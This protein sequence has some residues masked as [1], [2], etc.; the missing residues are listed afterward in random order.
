MSSYLVTSTYC[1]ANFIKHYISHLI[2]LRS[3]TMCSANRSPFA[4]QD[5]PLEIRQAIIQKVLD[6]II[7]QARQITTHPKLSTPAAREYR[8]FEGVQKLLGVSHQFG[9]ECEQPIELTFES[10]RKVH[11][12]ADHEEMRINS[13]KQ[14]HDHPLHYSEQ[15]AALEV[16]SH[17]QYLIKLESQPVMDAFGTLV[18]RIWR[19]PDSAPL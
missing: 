17:R 6:D 1:I 11:D 5:L 9:L 3:A 13:N 2:T 18:R 14:L 12:R 10:I 7:E 4:W 19:L 16:E 15:R 8:I